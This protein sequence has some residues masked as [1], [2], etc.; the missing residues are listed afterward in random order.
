MQYGF[1]FLQAEAD[2]FWRNRWPFHLGNQLPFYDAACQTRLHPNSELHRN[3]P[4]WI[5]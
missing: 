3:L 5:I 4:N 1:A 2:L